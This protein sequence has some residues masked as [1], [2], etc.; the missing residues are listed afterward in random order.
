M[1]TAEGTIKS[2]SIMI[3]PVSVYLSVSRITNGRNVDTADQEP[4]SGW[5]YSLHITPFLMI[6]ITVPMRL[7]RI[8]KKN[9][10]VS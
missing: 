7:I 3:I 1:K 4:S 8:F 5:M 10:S 6:S 9:E 2:K